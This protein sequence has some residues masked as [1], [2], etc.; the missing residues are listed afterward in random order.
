LPVSQEGTVFFSIIFHFHQPCGNFPWVIEDAYQ[1]AYLPLLKTISKYPRINTNLH[2]SGPL[3]LWL[4][5]NHPKY[6]DQLS[7]LIRKNQVEIM[8]GGFYEPIM[9]IIP[10]EDRQRQIQLMIDWWEKNFGIHPKGAWLAERVWVP[11]LPRTLY[12]MNIDFIFIDD[13]LFRIAGY[14][15]E[16]TFYAYLTEAEG[17]TV[18]V[19]PINEQIRYLI[20]W[21]DPKETIQY[22]KKGKDLAH[23]KIIVMFSDAEKMGLWPAGDRT[24]YDICYVS[25]YNGQRGWLLEFFEGILTNEWIKSILISDY[26]K[27]IHPRGLIYLPTSSYDRMSVWALPTPL[28]KKLE[29]LR[30]KAVLKEIP[31]AEDVLTFATGSFWQNFLVKY[32]Q[33]NIMHKRM[34]ICRKRADFAKKTFPHLQQE[35][36]SK[37]WNHIMAAQS[38]DAYWHGLFGG[39]YYP[40]LRHTIH[41]H[42]SQAEHLLDKIWEQ[43]GLEVP[44]SQIID[45]LLDGQPDGVLENSHI[46]CYISSLVGGAIFS[47]NLKQRGYNFLNVLTRRRESYHSDEMS[48]IND[49]FEKWMFQDHFLYPT[50]K[51]K[52]L[53]EDRFQDLGNF[54]NNLYKI[55]QNNGNKLS[56]QRNGVIKLSENSIHTSILKNYELES[57]KLMISYEIDFSEPIREGTLIFSPEINAIGVSYPYKTKGIINERLFDLGKPIYHPGCRTVEI[58]DENELEQVSITI[59]FSKAI[60]CY[61]FPIFSIPK[62]EHGWQ[63][64][65]QGTSIFPMININGKKLKFKVKILLTTI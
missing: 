20:P 15:E 62:S 53:Q 55:H 26:L 64:Q 19:L 18:I 17:K 61:S 11:D 23:E 47:L 45:V 50:I 54:A 14:S 28:R 51:K 34:M 57:S 43:E 46:S 27:K 40:F 30:Q 8:G 13:Y 1:K 2:Y 65:Y 63:R 12:D 21:K 56:L 41:R 38:N 10:E 22:L 7:M 44:T 32:S 60:K 5:K 39:V 29:N 42:I 48:T 35:T 49:R 3:L 36:Y 4:Q 6:L 33:S 31:F 58:R 9:A 24:T 16:E 37:I 25:G 52:A 59:H